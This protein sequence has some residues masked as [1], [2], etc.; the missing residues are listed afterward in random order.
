MALSHLFGPF[1]IFLALFSSFWLFL[2][3][4]LF[5]IFIALSYLF[6]SFFIFMALFIFFI[7]WALFVFWLFFGVLSWWCFNLFGS[8]GLNGS[9]L[10]LNIFYIWHAQTF[11]TFPDKNL[12]ITLDLLAAVVCS[13]VFIHF[14]CLK[15]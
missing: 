14:F 4:W 1:F 13:P 10:P 3:F 8:F 9:F 7:F 2:S 12:S 11:T 15:N 5:F 6:G